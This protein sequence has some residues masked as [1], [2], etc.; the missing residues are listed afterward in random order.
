M[1][2]VERTPPSRGTSQG[3]RGW[4]ISA[5]KGLGEAGWHAVP[6]PGGRESRKGEEARVQPRWSL[7]SGRLQ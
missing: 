5:G 4:V 6:L 3:P 1:R 2:R 7:V